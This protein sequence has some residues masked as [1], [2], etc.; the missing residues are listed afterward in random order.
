MNTQ[1]LVLQ[2]SPEIGNVSAEYILPENAVCIITL[3]HGAGAGMNHSFMLELANALAETGIATLRF[4]FPF[5][6]KKK[7]PADR[8][9][10]AHKTIDAAITKAKELFPTL[11]LFAAGKSFGGRMS[12]QYL[13]EHS[14]VD[15]KGIIFYGFPLHPAGKPSIDRAEHLKYVKQPMLFLQGTKDELATWNLIEP[16]C[17]SLKRATLVKIEGAD[18]SFKA[19][20][21]DVM[22]ILV[23]ETHNWVKKKM[24]K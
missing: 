9:P 19:G 20:K 23:K 8:P 12:S 16:L 6:E 7:G 18:H 22:S 1:S 10:V 21:K 17:N 2:V 13:A 24:K 15:V 4:N 5:M 11:P 14:D 3:A